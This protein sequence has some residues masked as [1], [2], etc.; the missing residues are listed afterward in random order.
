MSRSQVMLLAAA[1]VFLGLDALPA[2][3]QAVAPGAQQRTP[4][5]NVP[6]LP[7][8]EFLPPQ[9]PFFELPPAPPPRA[10]GLA[11]QRSLPVKDV[12]VEGNT[13]LPAAD[14]DALVQPYE[15]REVTLEELFRLKDEI[16]LAY[17]NAGYVNSGATLPDQDVTDGTV[18]FKIVEGGL[19]AIEITGTK[20]LSSAFLEQRLRLGAGPPLNVN[21]LQ[22]RLQLLL[23]DPTIRKLE[24]Q[25]LPGS[26]PGQA[27][28][29]VTVEEEPKRFSVVARGANDQ[30]PSIGANDVGLTFTWF[31]L[32]GR[33]DPL[34]LTGD[35]T[36]GLQEA[37]FYYSI[38]LTARDLRFH[39]GGQ[40]SNADVVDDDV[41]DLNIESS[42]KQITVGLGMPVIDTTTDRVGLDLSFN[43]ERNRT[44][45]LNEPFAF[46]PGTDDGRSDVSV[47]Q[48]TQDWQNRGRRR[49]ISLASTFNLGLP[50]LGATDNPCCEEPSGDFFYWFGQGQLAHRLFSDRDQVVLRGQ[51][52]IA[53]DALLA[54]QQYSLGGIDTVRGYFVNEVVRDSGFAVGLEYRYPLLDLW[55]RERIRGPEDMSLELV[56][57]VDYGYGVNHHGNPEDVD[58]DTLASAGLGLRWIWPPRVLAEVYWGNRFSNRDGDP[59][60]FLLENGINFRVSVQLY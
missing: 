34:V 23:Q 7:A 10:P 33:N 18:R 55:D 50:I 47:L 15:G 40:I 11:D 35:L 29:A 38:P 41:E 14:L 16:T 36:E 17:V 43:R 51:A 25:L 56:P 32:F 1:V 6:A 54:S 24:A 42:A 48:F 3:A 26:Q 20:Q 2:A 45:L 13:V 19:E 8:P 39:I 57:F 59:D 58:S 60:D 31:N 9:R 5:E 44:Y 27:R 28:L 52:Q 46:S 12:V 30:S 21:T 53:T 49:A 22:D 37:S 4:R